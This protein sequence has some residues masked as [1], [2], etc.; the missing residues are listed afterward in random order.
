M[1][2]TKEIK[3]LK[4]LITDRFVDDK[5]TELFSDRCYE[6]LSNKEKLAVVSLVAQKRRMK[7]SARA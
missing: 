6:E 2:D 7:I 5:I 1:S 3:E 4:A